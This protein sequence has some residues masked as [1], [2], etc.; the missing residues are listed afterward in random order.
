MDCSGADDDMWLLA[1]LY[2]VYL[3]D[4]LWNE[5]IKQI[6]FHCA[7]GQMSDISPLLL[8]T[9]N[10]PVYYAADDSFPCTKEKTGR[11]VGIAETVGDCPTWKIL[12][13]DTRKIIY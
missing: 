6:P 12:T 3:L 5:T 2:V 13:D 8:F 7:T 10:G 1:T 9:F 11:W 4:H